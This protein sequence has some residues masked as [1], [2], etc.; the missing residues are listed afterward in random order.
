M[1]SYNG[2]RRSS[3][4]IVTC[5]LNVC[6][7]GASITKIMR[8]SNL[9]YTQAHR[10][11]NSMIDKGML[12]QRTVNNKKIFQTTRYGYEILETFKD[13]DYLLKEKILKIDDVKFNFNTTLPYSID[14][15][16]ICKYDIYA[17]ILKSSVK[18]V[19][20]TRLLNILGTNTPRLSK[21]L[22]ELIENKLIVV[23]NVK[24][25]RRVKGV[26]RISKKG[27]MYL[28]IYIKLASM[29]AKESEREE[30]FPRIREEKIIGISGI[31]H[32]VV[33]VI[34]NGM[35]YAVKEVKRN[36]KLEI[37]KFLIIV[38]DIGLRPLL[39]VD[40]KIYLDNSIKDIIK[41]FNG[42][43]VRR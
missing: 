28:K 25:D 19:T 37:F 34:L 32:K 23:E 4:E 11:I 30:R 42:K 18:G 36:N 35:K 2:K 26:F 17:K 38:S 10:Y 22:K 40:K 12:T 16:Q 14:G 31:E 5:I 13:L 39:I 6:L 7:K 1:V 41:E 24:Y 29:L 21:Y 43:I 27:L 33:T 9:N 8:E 15:N 20:K 3:L